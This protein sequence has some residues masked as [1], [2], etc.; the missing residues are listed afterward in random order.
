[1]KKQLIYFVMLLLSTTALAQSIAVDGIHTIDGINY[2]LS[3]T[4]AT[5]VSGNYKFSGLTI[6]SVVTFKN[7][8][9]TVT[10][11]GDNAL[12]D[13]T[14]LKFIN[15]PR[16]VTSIGKYAL[17]GCTGLTSIEIPNTVTNIGN[18]AFLDCI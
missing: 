14:N 17:S 5:L 10:A 13:C 7:K 16:S 18:C 15:I 9:Y 11:I 6:P 8:S 12:E 1:M 3:G 4:S 2:N